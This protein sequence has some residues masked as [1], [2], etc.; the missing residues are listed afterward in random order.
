MFLFLHCLGDE[1]HLLSL[2]RNGI[3][4]NGKED[5]N[6]LAPVHFAAGAGKLRIFHFS[7][8]K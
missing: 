2:I 5:E 6:G 8:L 7:K 4:V 1:S 3:N